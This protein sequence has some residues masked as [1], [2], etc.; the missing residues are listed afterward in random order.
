MQ[1]I[2]RVCDGQTDP[3]L[4]AR[5]ALQIILNGEERHHA[6]GDRDRCPVGRGEQVR[7]QDEQR[8]AKA[9]DGEGRTAGH[10]RAGSEV[11]AREVEI[12]LRLMAWH[13]PAGALGQAECQGM[14]EHRGPNP[15]GGEDA[16]GFPAHQPRRQD[17]GAI[18]EAGRADPDREDRKGRPLRAAAQRTE[19]S[20]RAGGESRG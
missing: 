13:E 4:T 20:H 6:Q 7:L 19:A 2:I 12:V 16:V 10:Q 18:R 11:A 1:A 14:A 5:H 3:I 9:R 15:D 17:L 8:R